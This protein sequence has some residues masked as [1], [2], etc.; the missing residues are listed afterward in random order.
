MASFADIT[1][2]LSH[3]GTGTAAMVGAQ[4]DCAQLLLG[5]EAVPSVWIRDLFTLV[6]EWEPEQYTQ[7]FAGPVGR[8]DGPE[9]GCR[10]D[11]VAR[12]VTSPTVVVK[13]VTAPPLS[14]FGLS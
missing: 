9:G 11:V 2:L 4:A 6:G 5:D 12:D 14:S 8:L 7:G 10:E 1:C 3:V 13:A